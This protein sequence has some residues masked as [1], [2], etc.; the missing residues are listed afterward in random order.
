MCPHVLVISIVQRCN[1]YANEK[2][3]KATFWEP[4]A[5]DADPTRM[6][7]LCVGFLSLM[8]W[9]FLCVVVA[10]IVS[11]QDLI[12]NLDFFSSRVDFNTFNVVVGPFRKGLGPYMNKQP[13][14]FRAM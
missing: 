5:S 9:S 3:R 10:D 8:H 1:Y 12:Y 11:P 14:D 2:I 6:F 4:G 13:F 7:G